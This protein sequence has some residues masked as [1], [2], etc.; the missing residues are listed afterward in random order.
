MTDLAYRAA[1]RAIYEEGSAGT[2]D[3]PIGAAVRADDLAPA[4]PGAW[5][6]AWVWVPDSAAVA[7]DPLAVID[8]PAFVRRA[9]DRRAAQC[10]GVA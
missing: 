7:H 9:M 1:A 8:V 4:D 5:I 10:E 6:E 2:I 3:I